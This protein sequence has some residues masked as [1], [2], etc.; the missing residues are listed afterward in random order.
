MPRSTSLNLITVPV[1]VPF[2]FV[3]LHTEGPCPTVAERGEGEEREGRGG[4]GK[5]GR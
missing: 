1:L 4:R 3:S 5:E 2:L